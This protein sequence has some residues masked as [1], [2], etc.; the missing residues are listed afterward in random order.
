MWSFV[1][2]RSAGSAGEPLWHQRNEDW[3]Y[4]EAHFTLYPLPSTHISHFCWT[5]PAGRYGAPLGNGTSLTLRYFRFNETAI[6]FY[7]LKTSPGGYRSLGLGGR[8]AGYGAPAGYGASS[9]PRFEM[10]SSSSA[11]L[12]TFCVSG[13][14]LGGVST[15]GLSFG[16]GPGGKR[17]ETHDRLG[18]L[19][20][21]I[22]VFWL[23]EPL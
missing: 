6:W 11:L 23:L 15:N 3:T 10:F 5:F 22:S 18:I 21:N 9:Q 14:G 12:T 13:Q 4:V 2:F 8:A 16:L 17:G 19:F 1:S 20:L 7:F